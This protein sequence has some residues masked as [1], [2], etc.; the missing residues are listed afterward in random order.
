MK[1]TL[2][3]MVPSTTHADIQEHAPISSITPEPTTTPSVNV[4]TV[5]MDAPP[6]GP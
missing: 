1:Y 5:Q 2:G 4:Q 6:W 3:E